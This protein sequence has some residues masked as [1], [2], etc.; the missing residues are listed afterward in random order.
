MTPDFPPGSGP[1]QWPASTQG[2]S[3]QGY[4]P[5]QTPYQP[6]YYGPNYS[7]HEGQWRLRQSAVGAASFIIGLLVVIG[8][9]GGFAG[10][11]MYLIKGNRKTFDE[12]AN[13]MIGGV[14][15]CGA[16]LS[17]VGLGLGVGCLFERNRKKSLGITGL[18]LNALVVAGVVFLVIFGLA[19]KN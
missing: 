16:L 17:L 10:M 15:I 13:A 3:F 6:N 7:P 14:F 8:L 12:S 4:P 19:M 5:G 11:V 1:G 9:A 2:Q 18:I